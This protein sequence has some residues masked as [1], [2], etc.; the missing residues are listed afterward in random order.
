MVHV[1][2]HILSTNFINMVALFL[3]KYSKDKA[4]A[5]QT[6]IYDVQQIL[7]TSGFLE[8]CRNELPGL[9]IKSKLDDDYKEKTIIYFLHEAID[10]I[11]LNEREG[12]IIDEDDNIIE[13]LKK[14]IC[15]Y[16]DNYINI[17]VNAMYTLLIEQCS[18]LV[19]QGK[20]LKILLLL[21]K[22]AMYEN[23]Y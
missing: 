13:Q 15:K 8:Y 17:Y 3:T 23:G 1:F 16:F 21:G 4:P 5:R 20:H 22:K 18:A 7:E 14:T 9:I 12:I 2:K 19:Q 11:K 6:L 10:L